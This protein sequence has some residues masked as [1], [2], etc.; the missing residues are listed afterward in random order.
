MRRE[1]S[2]DRPQSA[3]PEAHDRQSTEQPEM[4]VCAVSVRARTPAPGA[5]PGRDHG[6]DHRELGGPRP[7]APRGRGGC[8]MRRLATAHSALA[9]GHPPRAWRLPRR[10]RL[11]DTPRA[12]RSRRVFPTPAP[13]GSCCAALSCPARAVC[14]LSS[15][16]GEAGLE[17]FSHSSAGSTCCSHCARSANSSGHA[18]WPMPSYSVRM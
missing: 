8:G 14:V 12:A 1:T 11:R 4:P 7:C 6:R 5:G 3:E 9:T 16:I 17:I 10:A 13:A 18:L 15:V 2:D